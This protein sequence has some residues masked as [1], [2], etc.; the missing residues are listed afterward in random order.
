MGLEDYL[1]GRKLLKKEIPKEYHEALHQL[2][3]C[4][5]KSIV[6]KKNKMLCKR[7]GFE[8]NQLNW[9]IV[10][11]G[12]DFY[13][14]PTCI[15]LG[16]VENRESFYYVLEKEK[17]K[18]QV[19]LTWQGELTKA[20]Q[21]I[22]KDLMKSFK[23]KENHLVHAVTGAG[24]TE[25]LFPLVHLALGKG[26][27]I[28]IVSPRIDVCLELL[29][30][31][32][33]A[34]KEEDIILLYG[35]KE[36]DY[37]YTSFVIA[38]VHQLLRFYQAFDLIVVD[39]VD[40]FPYAGN[41]YLEYGIKTSLK[42][43][44]SL[45]Y[46]TATP[47]EELKKRVSMNE[48]NLSYLPNRYHGHALPVPSCHF[49][50][51][52]NQQLFKGR[53]TRSMS[54]ILEKQSKACLIFFPNIERMKLFYKILRKQFPNKRIAYVYSG[55]DDREKLIMAMRRGGLDWLLTTTILERGVT[56]SNIDVI[57]FEANHRTF[58]TA[59]LVQI[60]GRVGRKND[61]PTGNIYFFHTGKTK[62]INNSVAQ[63]KEMNRKGGF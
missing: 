21:K 8:D 56:F 15:L 50:Y 29:P 42:K 57:V 49:N 32:K 26:C 38:T 37:R 4:R 11:K 2:G 34:F 52:L 36:E 24:K 39:E 14:C 10:S 62:S 53:L 1:M 16:R 63:I 44:G 31:F 51:F 27:R 9:R 3:I 22:A 30:R 28:A 55:K 59:S 58:T 61:F 19:R 18:R 60:A 35:K 7:C 54:L 13:Y 17:G 25:M 6:M 23:R 47:S 48:L 40:A 45:V 12:T 20:Q 33:E 5:E 46:L 43:K 41:P